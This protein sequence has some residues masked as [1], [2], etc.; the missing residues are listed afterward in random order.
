ME[1]WVEAAGWA[2]ELSRLSQ[3]SR[4]IKTSQTE[5]LHEQIKSRAG[6][7]LSHKKR[8]RYHYVL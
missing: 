2:A 7:E 5:L 8:I 3:G 6:F 1:V 4:Y